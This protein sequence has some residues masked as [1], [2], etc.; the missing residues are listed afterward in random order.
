MAKSALALAQPTQTQVIIRAPN[1]Q[2]VEF[3]VRGTAPYVQHRFWK[4]AQMME[5]QEAGSTNQSKSRKARAPRDFNNDYEQSKHI[6]TEGWCGIPAPAFRNAMISSCRVAGFVM[7]RAK[8]SVF[9]VPDGFDRDDGT[10]LVKIIGE[11]QMHTGYA[12][13]SDG[14]VDIRARAMFPNWKCILRVR[15]DA[16]Q[17]TATDVTNLVERAGLQV[18][19]GEGRPDSPKGA[20]MGWGTWTTR[21]EEELHGK[22]KKRT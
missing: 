5:T 8:L 21:A 6:S 13:N 7:T 4:K 19:V 15:Y 16:D 12:K 9:V 18:G 22:R 20:G 14:S 1:L 17:F 2:V 11:P 10:P 3:Q